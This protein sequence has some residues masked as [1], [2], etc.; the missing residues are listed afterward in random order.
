MYMCVVFPVTGGDK[1]KHR[2]L[3]SDKLTS[4][5]DGVEQC[6]L[7]TL[8]ASKPHMLMAS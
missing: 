3:P 4:F 7:I 8:N 5:T 6:E 1:Y 2:L